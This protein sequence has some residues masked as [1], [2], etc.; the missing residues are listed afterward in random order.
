MAWAE[1][2]LNF[3]ARMAWPIT[4]LAAAALFRGPVAAL[5]SRVR[6]VKTPWA[7][8]Q[9]DR[10]LRNV[11]ERAIMLNTRD[12]AVS[13]D[14]PPTG[15]IPEAEYAIFETARAISRARVTA[16]TPSERV[17]RLRAAIGEN[18]AHALGTGQ[19]N[20]TTSELV[21]TLRSAGAPTDL[22]TT[23]EQVLSLGD[24]AS[25]DQPSNDGA[26]DYADACEQLLYALAGWLRTRR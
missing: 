10:E 9:I 11:K 18:L 16:G 23:V 21:G 3:I 4:V 24:A 5:I 2:I 17:A 13:D 8:I 20:A 14:G 25:T 26:N 1:L 15:H 19:P 12:A 6:E 22:T 7:T